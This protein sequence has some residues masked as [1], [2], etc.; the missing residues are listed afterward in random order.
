MDSLLTIVIIIALITIVVM[1]VKGVFR[2]AII[3]IVG[4]LVF[5]IFFGNGYE[6]VSKAAS[7][8]DEDLALKIE[9]YYSEFRDRSNENSPLDTQAM[10]DSTV[11]Y[12]NGRIDLAALKADLEGFASENLTTEKIEEFAILFKAAVETNTLT[13]ELTLFVQ[14]NFNEETA[15]A[16]LDK[17][18]SYIIEQDSTTESFV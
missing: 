14:N 8:F 5:N 17:I 2:I 7:Y 12:I 10:I 15:Q 11:E 1:L 9:S 13:E 3:V 18:Q 4:F 16:L 6:Y